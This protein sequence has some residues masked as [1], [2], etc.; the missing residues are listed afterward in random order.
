MTSA[1]P[2]SVN[3][4]YIHIYIHRPT[5]AYSRQV[6]EI[7][8]SLS[9]LWIQLSLSRFANDASQWKQ[10]LGRNIIAVNLGLDK[11]KIVI[12]TPGM[13]DFEP[14]HVSNSWM[15]FKL[16][17]S[18]NF[19]GPPTNTKPESEFK[20]KCK[21]SIYNALLPLPPPTNDW[22]YVSVIIQKPKKIVNNYYNFWTVPTCVEH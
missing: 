9:F 14:R 10:F 7:F 16:P 13:L 5:Y 19:K 20:G 11:F 18:K 15:T 12:F 17:V 4:A 22:K 3:S 8:T 6:S 1:V 2:S 21:I